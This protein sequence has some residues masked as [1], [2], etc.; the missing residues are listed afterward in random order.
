[1]SSNL[2]TGF[3][4]GILFFTFYGTELISNLFWFKATNYWFH[5]LLKLKTMS[6]DSHFQNEFQ[7][8]FFKIEILN[9]YLQ[10]SQWKVLCVGGDV[11]AQYFAAKK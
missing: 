6:D 1:M 3:N 5:I 4:W 2:F 7:P 10:V 8:V 11:E 9:H